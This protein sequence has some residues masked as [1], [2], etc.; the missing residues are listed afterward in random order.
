MEPKPKKTKTDKIILI[1]II[2]FM[3]LA[4]LSVVVLYNVRSL[5]QERMDLMERQLAILEKE[6][7]KPSTTPNIVI[8][9]DE[10]EPDDIPEDTESYTCIARR[11][12]KCYQY[13]DTTS[14]VFGKLKNGE[15]IQ[16]AGEE[17]G[18]YICVK[19]SR[20]C[21]VQ[22][23]FL[24]KDGTYAHVPGAVDL[25]E[26]LPNAE[27]ELRFASPNNIT[28]H[29][30]YPAIPIMEENTAY[31]LLEAAKIFERDGYAIKVYDAYRPK[32]AQYELYDIVNDT[33]FIANPYNGNS[34]HHYGRA[35]DMSLVDMR[36]G[37]ELEMP[38]D[39]HT[40]SMAAARTNSKTWTE[41]A[42]NNVDYMTSVMK[43]VGFGTITTEWWHFENTGSGGYLA[44]DMDLTDPVYSGLMQ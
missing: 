14:A 6:S 40:F 44:V 23:R 20:L 8:V 38:T 16:V 15:H 18:Y 35:I 26:F 19:D 39:M 13:P 4:L 11:E 28:G 32:S 33:R 2:V 25:R 3:F 7:T 27:F 1:L 36:T 30:M 17:S 5:Q 34:W 41:A 10:P 21:Y 22:K 9:Y 24:T 31:M 37:I 12:A 43:S 42:K 29:A